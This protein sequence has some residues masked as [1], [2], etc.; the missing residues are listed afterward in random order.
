LPAGLAVASV[1]LSRPRRGGRHCRVDAAVLAQE[2][3]VRP[4]FGHDP[5]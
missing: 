1:E 5:D 3:R 2:L 4:R